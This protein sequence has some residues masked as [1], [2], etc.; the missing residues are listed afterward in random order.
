[1]FVFYELLYFE[2][3]QFYSV[4]TF[5]IQITAGRFRTSF[6]GSVTVSHLWGLF[7]RFVTRTQCGEDHSV[8]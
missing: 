7:S 6:I 5:N 3:Q 8:R 2:S 4:M 1:M